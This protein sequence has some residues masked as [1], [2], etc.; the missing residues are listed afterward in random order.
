MSP[1]AVVCLLGDEITNDWEPLLRPINSMKCVVSQGVWDTLNHATSVSAHS[2]C[3]AGTIVEWMIVWKICHHQV[4]PGFLPLFIS[5]FFFFYSISLHSKQGILMSNLTSWVNSLT[6]RE[7]PTKK[8]L[9]GQ[10]CLPRPVGL[11]GWSMDKITNH[12][13]W[14]LG[15]GV[16]RRWQPLHDAQF[17]YFNCELEL[18]DLLAFQAAIS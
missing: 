10:I 16:N 13:N 6:R 2:W 18:L 7:G 4:F 12:L 14:S 17:Y 3:Y 9:T 8:T 11:A 1:D 5:S 15:L